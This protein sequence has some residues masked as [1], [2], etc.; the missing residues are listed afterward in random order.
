MRILVV[1]PMRTGSTWIHEMLI[2]LLRPRR[3]DYVERVEEAAAILAASDRCV[4]KSHSLTARK[5]RE[6]GAGLYSVRVLR[7]YKDSLISRAL[8][9]R[10]VRPAEGNA[11]SPEEDRCIHECK[12][13]DDATFVNVF[14]RECP[15]V[16]RWIDEI[17]SFDSGDFDWTFYYEMLLHNPLDQLSSWLT[18][19]GFAEHAGDRTVEQALEACSFSRMRE[20]HTRGFVGST[21]VGRWMEILD[22]RLS[23]EIDC[24]YYERR[25]S[26]SGLRAIEEA[27][28][29]ITY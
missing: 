9:C 22:P 24:R 7:N 8:Y 17:I 14:L 16:L 21:G 3:C 10:H 12:D 2:F 28:R 26:A 13:L 18:S 1:S 19:S 15:A 25:K 11:N 29:S 23:K 6:I 20:A 27:Q 5:L 4:L